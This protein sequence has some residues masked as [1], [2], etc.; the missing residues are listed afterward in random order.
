MAQEKM[1]LD[2][3][4]PPGS[5]TAPGDG[6]RLRRSNSAPLIHGLRSAVFQENAVRNVKV[7]AVLIHRI[8]IA[9]ISVMDQV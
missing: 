9:M 3:E 7:V 2:L 1:E 6:S 5:A 8:T 4:L